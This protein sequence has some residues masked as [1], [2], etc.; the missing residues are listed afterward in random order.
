MRII[1]R[2]ILGTHEI[3]S[4]PTPGGIPVGIPVGALMSLIE[5]YS[6]QMITRASLSKAHKRLCCSDNTL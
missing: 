5:D 3:S 1:L 6:P 2:D 4:L